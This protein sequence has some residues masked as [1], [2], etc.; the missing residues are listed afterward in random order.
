MNKKEIY[1]MVAGLIYDLLEVDIDKEEPDVT[2]ADLDMDSLDEIELGLDLEE[3]F[4]I[5][6]PDEDLRR[7]YGDMTV[8]DLVEYI[9]KKMEG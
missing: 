5:E 1:N 6:I 4:D 3:T 8:S 2:L 7:N 9:A